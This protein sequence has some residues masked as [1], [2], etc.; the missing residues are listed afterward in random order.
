[1]GGEHERTV[2]AAVFLAEQTTD[3]DDVEVGAVA[4]Q[5]HAPDH[6]DWPLLLWNIDFRVDPGEKETVD[7]LFDAI[8]NSSPNAV[9]RATA[10]YFQASRNMRQVNDIGT[11]PDDRERYREAAFAAAR[12][13]SAGVEDEPFKTRRDRDPITLAEA[14]ANLL[15]SFSFAV[16][17]TVPDVT[18]VRLD[19]TEESLSSYVDQVVLVDFWAT[20]CPPCVESLPKLRELDESLPDE[21][22]EILSISVDDVAATVTEFQVDEPMPWANWHIGPES[23]ILKSWVIRGYPTYLLVDADGTVLA[24]THDLDDDLAALIERTVNGMAG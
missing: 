17:G 21:R 19:G 10:R 9:H 12:G 13:L 7:A 22:F 8:A 15:N 14:E 1:M 6:E 5:R 11:D 24:R 23:D 2:D 16:G 20:W 3:A 4:L 18:A